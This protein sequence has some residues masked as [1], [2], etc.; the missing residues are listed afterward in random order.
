MSCPQNPQ[1]DLQAQDRCHRIG[2]TQ[3]VMVYRLVTA[4]T[5]DQRIVERA[6]T[7][8]RLEKMVIH[9]G[10][11]FVVKCV[12]ECVII[13]TWCSIVY[14]CGCVCC[15]D[16]LQENRAYRGKLILIDF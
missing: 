7:K 3:P 9:K 6:A 5:I 15:H 4:N 14:V 13:V 16:R 10:V 1:A 11:C 12:C 8:R 2:Q